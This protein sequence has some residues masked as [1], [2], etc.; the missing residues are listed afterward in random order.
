MDTRLEKLIEK[1]G[2]NLSIETIKV[3]EEYLKN[4]PQLTEEEF[5]KNIEKIRAAK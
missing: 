4:H 5:I 3:L 1:K 2:Y